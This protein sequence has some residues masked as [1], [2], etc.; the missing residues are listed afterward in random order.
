MIFGEILK[1]YND[2]LIE[3]AFTRFYKSYL[4]NLYII[5]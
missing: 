4:V 2:P 5:T 3:K 1:Y